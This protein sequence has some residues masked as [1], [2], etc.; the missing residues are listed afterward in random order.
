MAQ[1][2]E[3]AWIAG[4]QGPVEIGH[5]GR[6][7]PLIVKVRA[8][9]CGWRPML[10]ADRLVT[11]REWQAFIEDGG[12]GA[13]NLWLSDGWAWVRENAIQAPLYW[14]RDREAN[15]DVNSASMG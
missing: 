1:V 12:Y 13:A 10:L 5:A 6:S 15:G 4:R 7:L 14:K 8:T 3:A 2:D 9:L 11:N